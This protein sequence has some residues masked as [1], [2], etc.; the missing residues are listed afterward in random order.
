VGRGDQWG[1]SGWIVILF[2]VGGHPADTKMF[3][4]SVGADYLGEER[5]SQREQ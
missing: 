3:E 2:I 4:R 1:G 5:S